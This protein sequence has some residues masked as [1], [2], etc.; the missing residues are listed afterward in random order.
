MRAFCK[1]ASFLISF[2]SSFFIFHSL[3]LAY[4]FSVV[5]GN[6]P[7][8]LNLSTDGVISGIPT[9][10]GTYT[11]KV[12]VTDSASNE[13]FKDFTL[14]V[15]E[16]D[17]QPPSKPSNFTAT[18]GDGQIKLSWINPE[19]EDLV[20]ILVLYKNNTYPIDYNDDDAILLDNIINVTPGAE[21]SILHLGLQNCNQYYYA[22][23]AY[24]EAGNYSQAAK[25][26]ATPGS[27]CNVS[28]VK[29]MPWLY[30]LLGE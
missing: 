20:G 15:K 21:V 3:S 28:E 27:N 1:I 29:P 10:A 14:T 6:L 2:L 4:T 5:S 9:K 30:L 13:A 7:P 23:F 12:K 17:V 8:G 16:Q 19:D 11:F 22:A 25:A 24:D 18:P 26:M